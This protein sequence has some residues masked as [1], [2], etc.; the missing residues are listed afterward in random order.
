M[1]PGISG[2]VLGLNKTHIGTEIVNI[3]YGHK[4]K[5]VSGLSSMGVG[6]IGL[7][8][9]LLLHFHYIF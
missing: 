3:R 6:T 7:E 4:T 2:S 1:L 8:E 5:Y 9:I